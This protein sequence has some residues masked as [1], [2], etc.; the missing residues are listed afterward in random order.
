MELE[1]KNQD[2]DE[3]AK[4]KEFNDLADL[5]IDKNDQLVKIL[6]LLGK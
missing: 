3:E 2:I 5:K 6:E 4:R 1:M